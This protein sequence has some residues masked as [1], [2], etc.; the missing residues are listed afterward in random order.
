MMSISGVFAS[1]GVTIGSATGGLA[2]TQGFQLLGL[3][4]GIFAIV[5]AL[6]IL[7]VA[8]EPCAPIKIL[9]F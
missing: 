1:I 4:L 6:I 3:S 2:L 9:P 5:A 8:K 7:F